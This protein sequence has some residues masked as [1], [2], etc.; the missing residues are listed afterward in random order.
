M[1]LTGKVAIVTGAS[2]GIGASIV[3]ALH[4]IGMKVNNSFN[5]VF[6]LTMVRQVVGFARRKE[7]IEE[8]IKNHE[9]R[10]FAL[11][12]DVTKEQEILN[13]FAW[14]TENLGP[15]HVLVNN[16][17][18]GATGEKSGIA[19]GD[20]S[21]WERIMNTNFNSTLLCCR[22]TIRNMQE[23]HVD[24][25][26][27]NISSVAGLRPI[28]FP[29]TLVYSASKSALCA[30]TENMRLELLRMDSKIRTTVSGFILSF[31][32]YFLGSCSV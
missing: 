4:G 12:V 19:K 9:G 11:K 5:L 6:M 26:I 3:K 1:D 13:G 2:S 30:L 16:A 22:E 18:V 27:I 20:V 32:D 10:L 8:L 25:Y 28:P 31:V 17:G 24:G 15:I 14:V 7:R 21:V 29:N 23:N